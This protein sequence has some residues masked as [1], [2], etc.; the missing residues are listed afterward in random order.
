M[1][2]DGLVL[3]TGGTGV[4]GSSL[5][6]E[7]LAAGEKVAC[8]VHSTPLGEGCEEVESYQGSLTEKDL[9]LDHWDW[10]ELAQ[11]TRAIIHCAAVV[12]FNAERDVIHGLNVIGTERILEFAAQAEAPIIYTSSAFIA[13]AELIA[14]EESGVA[15][16]LNE[17]LQSKLAAEETVRQSGLRYVIARPPL[18]GADSR[19]G[20]ITHEQAM[21]KVLRGISTGTLPF[22]PWGDDA[23]VDFVPQ[24]IMAKK[25]TSLLHNDPLDGGEFW[26][27][28]GAEALPIRRLV[29]SC[30]NT[31]RDHGHEVT[32]LPTFDIE[33]V[34]RLIVPAFMGEFSDR[35]QRRFSGLVALSKI[36]GTAEPFPSD[37]DKIPGGPPPLKEDYLYEQLCHT[38][39]VNYARAQAPA[40]A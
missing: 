22:M 40:A 25:L 1:S 8:L 27:T 10:S 32:R 11:R 37:F 16:G 23:L 5:V 9:G 15:G 13:R 30:V 29:D 39:E 18:L 3:V 21:H 35:D 4:V 7:L 33:M 14:G 17:Y 20:L 24:D 36:F 31:M 19:T 28:V 38:V 34:E 26:I 12:E 6:Q 2:D